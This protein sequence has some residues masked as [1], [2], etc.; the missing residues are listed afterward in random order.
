[1]QRFRAIGSRLNKRDN[2][3]DASDSED[4]SASAVEYRL[5]LSTHSANPFEKLK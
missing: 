3:T 5:C 4:S 1:M 2:E